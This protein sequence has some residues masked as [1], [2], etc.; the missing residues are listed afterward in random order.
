MMF[1]IGILPALLIVYIKRKSR[2]RRFTPETESGASGYFLAI[3]E[4]HS[5][6]SW[7]LWERKVDIT[8]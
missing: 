4:R 8:R 1:W 3:C 2:S 7:L 5:L 6:F